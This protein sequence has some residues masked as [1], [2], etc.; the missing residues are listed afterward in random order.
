MTTRGTA[1]VRFAEDGAGLRFSTEVEAVGWQALMDMGVEVTRGTLIVPYT[2]VTDM[3]GVLT[4]KSL[5]DAEKQYLDVPTDGWFAEGEV[6]HVFTGAV[7]GIRFENY[8][9]NYSAVGYLKITYTNGETAY[10]IG[11]IVEGDEKIDLQ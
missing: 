2:Y 9:R 4:H 7:S 6:P 11:S 10:V 5:I 8:T 1:T 3:G